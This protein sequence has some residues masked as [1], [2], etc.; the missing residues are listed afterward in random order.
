M[1]SA[2]LLTDYDHITFGNGTAFV[3][4][5]T[6]TVA[7]RFRGEEAT[8]N[9][10]QFRNC[11]KFRA[12]SRIVLGIPDSTDAVAPVNSAANSTDVLQQQLVENN[13]IYA[14]L[15]EQAVREDAARLQHEQK[16]AL[17]AAAL[18]RSERFAALEKERQKNQLELEASTTRKSPITAPTK[19]GAHRKLPVSLWKLRQAQARRLLGKTRRWRSVP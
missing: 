18:A 9:V 3:L 10:V 11:Q 5:V 12:K 1:Q 19:E 7:T 15:R 16:T 6:A 13:T 14:I 8:R 4:P 17:N 2:E